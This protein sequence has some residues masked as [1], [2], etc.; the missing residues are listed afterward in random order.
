MLGLIGILLTCVFGLAGFVFCV[1]VGVLSKEA[2]CGA[3]AAGE[4]VTVVDTFESGS[5]DFAF[6]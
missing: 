2:C 5:T 6:G 3:L 1:D 4:G